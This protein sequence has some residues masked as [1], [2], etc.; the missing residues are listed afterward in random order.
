[1][2]SFHTNTCIETAAPRINC[3]IDDSSLETMPDIDQALLQFIYVMNLTNSLPHF[4]HILQ[5][6]WFRPA[7]LGAKGLVKCACHPRRLSVPRAR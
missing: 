7:L 1:M 4:P 6:I 5:S 3:V 2:S